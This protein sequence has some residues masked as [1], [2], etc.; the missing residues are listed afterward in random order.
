MPIG[1]IKRA[2]IW[3]RVNISSVALC[4][5]ITASPALMTQASAFDPGDVWPSN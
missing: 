4:T 2:S 3:S 1:L 5:Y